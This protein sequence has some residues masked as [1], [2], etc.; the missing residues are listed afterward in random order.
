ML[1][2]PDASVDRLLVAHA[3][4]AVERPE[5][6]LEEAWRVTAGEGRVII[7]VPSR[8]GIW[9]R[10]DVTPFGQGS[11]YSRGQLR[12]LLNRAIFSPIFWDEALYFPPI[13]KN[14]IVRSAPAIER[15]GAV[16]N[17]PFAG[18]HIV[19]AKK[20]IHRPAGGRAVIR[21]R[22]SPMRP[23]LPPQPVPPSGVIGDYRSGEERTSPLR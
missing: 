9:A 8:R 19:E 17:F 13:P 23:A 12:E 16:L 14:Y 4:E 3:L 11:P 18:V 1:P 22:L 21:K 15:L 20:Q 6:L 2:L 5:T 7:V 10:A